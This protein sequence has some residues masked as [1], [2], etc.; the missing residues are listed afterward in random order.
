MTLPRP[1]VRGTDLVWAIQT[2]GI[3]RLMEVQIKIARRNI[4]DLEG[5]VFQCNYQLETKDFL[6]AKKTMDQI[7]SILPEEPP[8]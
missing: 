5:L 4:T 7:D 8:R 6:A 2:E 3:L 1:F